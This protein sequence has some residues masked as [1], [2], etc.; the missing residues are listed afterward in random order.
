MAGLF[1]DN[2]ER[3]TR[4]K[5]LFGSF[6]DIRQEISDTI[7]SVVDESAELKKAL[8]TLQGQGKVASMQELEAKA[9]AQ[10][11]EKE[12]E[13]YKELINSVEK[14][15]HDLWVAWSV[16]MWV[17]AGYA[18]VMLP[19]EITSRIGA[20]MVGRALNQ[21]VNAAQVGLN[22]PAA[23]QNLAANGARAMRPRAGAFHIPAGAP[24]LAR[25]QRLENFQK[26][27]SKISRIGRIVGLVL[28]AATLVL[29]AVDLII[30]DN[31]RT[32]LM[33]AIK[34]LYGARHIIKQ[35]AMALKSEAKH[36]TDARILLNERATKE[37]TLS[38][39]VA[40]KDI[41]VEKKNEIMAKYDAEKK[42]E[43]EAKSPNGGIP[44]PSDKDVYDVLKARD[45]LHKSWQNND[46]DYQG[47]LDWLKEE[48]EK[49]DEKH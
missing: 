43:V 2:T 17:D 4:L 41:T 15:D 14:T 35:L 48:A 47:L 37:S 7:A 9:K 30:Q 29:V 3:Q 28:L 36:V 45:D 11:T 6:N 26:L 23:A 38:A 40:S 18:T 19:I 32:D 44:L 24:Q 42:A 46:P 1:F 12:Y 34:D 13:E 27:M 8:E 39:L 31:Q 10:M 16:M 33:K 5:D 25:L 21:A 20:F 49:P 22:I